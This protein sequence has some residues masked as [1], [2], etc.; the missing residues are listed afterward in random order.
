MISW[1]NMT[2]DPRFGPRTKAGLAL[3]KFFKSENEPSQDRRPRRPNRSLGLSVRRLLT[4]L[5]LVSHFFDDKKI[6]QVTPKLTTCLQELFWSIFDRF[7]LIPLE[8]LFHAQEIFMWS[9]RKNDRLSKWSEISFW[10]TSK[11]LKIDPFSF[12]WIFG[13]N[14]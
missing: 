8:N 6:Q 12:T 14:F 2:R 4:R 3:V 7:I 11:L 9:L 5:I 1:S 13:N 10:F